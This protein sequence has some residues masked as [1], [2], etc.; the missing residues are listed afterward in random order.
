[1]KDLGPHNAMWLGD[2]EW[3]SWDDFSLNTSPGPLLVGASLPLFRA[4]F[5]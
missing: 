2:G 1:M 3:L 5:F 4:V